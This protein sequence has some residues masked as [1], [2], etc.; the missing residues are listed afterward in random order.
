MA[1]AS[2]SERRAAELALIEQVRSLE[3]ETRAARR[4][5]RL[6]ADTVVVMHRKS[7]DASWSAYT[8][9]QSDLSTVFESA[10]ALY[11]EELEAARAGQQL[12]TAQARFLA[13]TGRGDLLGVTLPP[14]ERTP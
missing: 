11:R 4:T 3:V 2:E 5:A 14:I 1:R 10:H 12:A 9:G 13:L 7:V 6:L 8:A